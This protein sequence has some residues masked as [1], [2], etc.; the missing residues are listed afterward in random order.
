[1]HGQRVYLVTYDIADAKR[2]R[3][4]HKLMRGYGE[5]LQYSIF[6]CRLD[7]RDRAELVADLETLISHNQDHVLLFDL[8]QPQSV[9][10]N[11]TSLGKPYLPPDTS[12]MIF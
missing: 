8:G 1:M 11:I 4:V 5:W 3:Q 10:M 2:L 7:A 9:E 12:P 6:Q